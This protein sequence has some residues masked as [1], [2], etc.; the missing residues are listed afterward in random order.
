MRSQPLLIASLALAACDSLTAPR[1]AEGLSIAMAPLAL[2]GLSK[3][4]YD[5]RVTN[6]ADGAGATV[7]AE[8]DPTLAGADDAGSLCSTQFGNAGG[9]GLTFVGAC[10]ASPVNVGDPGRMNSVTLWVDSLFD[11]GGAQIAKDGPDGW[12]DPCPSGC[13]LNALCQENTD[14]KVDFNLTILRQANQGFFDI[15][16]NFEDVFC[17]AKVDCIGSDGQPLK[18][19]FRPGTGAR[20]TTVVAAFACTAGAGVGTVLYRDPVKITCGATTTELA[21]DVGRGNAWTNASADPAPSD[22][23]WQY[24]IYAGNESLTCNGK[25]CNKSYW[26]LAFGLD[27][28]VDNCTL[29]TRMTASAGT[30]SQFATPTSHTYPYIDIN[31]PLTDAAGLTCSKHQLDGASGVTT[32]YTPISTPEVFDF[33]F[34]G[35]TFSKRVAVCSPSCQNGGV[36]SATEVC[37]CPTDWTGP[38]CETPSDADLQAFLTATA[39]TDPTQVSALKTLVT[40]LKVDG[41][42]SKMKAIYPM[43][44]GTE[45]RH[46]FNLKDPRDLDAAFRLKFYGTWLHTATGAK[47]DGATAYANSY[48][49]PTTMLGANGGSLG[50]YSRTNEN[51]NSAE[52]GAITTSPN[53]ERYFQIHAR[54]SAVYANKFYGLPNSEAPSGSYLTN[55]DSRGFYQASRL[56]STE[57]RMQKDNTLSGNFTAPYVTPNHVVYVGARNQNGSANYFSGKECAFAYLGES[58]TA[59]ELNAYYAAVQAFQTALGRQIAP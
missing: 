21:P 24:A 38:S 57:C 18:L 1:A 54:F 13:T 49:N 36:C 27:A 6:A 20:D 46:K 48:L 32:G 8:G 45:A 29:T 10:D 56:S 26:N 41:I 30:L 44:G 34:D 40:S 39:I 55:L 19:L 9:G 33:G 42:W 12:Q 47:P 4:C 35:A 31:V 15:G 23:I 14:T 7:W 50:Y 17:S 5:L 11:A 58:L 53:P 52:I 28:S 3:V 22:A 59:A 37:T 51:T 25:P 16:V 2:P 43:V